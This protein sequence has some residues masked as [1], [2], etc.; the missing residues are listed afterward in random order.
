MILVHIII[1]PKG[2]HQTSVEADMGEEKEAKAFYRKIK[3]H[4]LKLNQQLKE[5]EMT[6]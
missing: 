6:V 2:V 3:P 5:K 1:S 4:L